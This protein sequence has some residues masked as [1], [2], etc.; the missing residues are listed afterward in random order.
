MDSSQLVPE[1]VL[2]PLHYVILSLF[3]THTNGGRERKDWGWD[4]AEQHR[5]CFPTNHP[6]ETD[7]RVPLLALT[8]LLTFSN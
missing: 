8:C 4:G 5:F 2:Q 6:G 7:R 1:S 3:P